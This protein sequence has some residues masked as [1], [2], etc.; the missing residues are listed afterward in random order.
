VTKSGR[1]TVQCQIPYANIE[2]VAIQK[3]GDNTVIAIQLRVLD[4]HETYHTDKTAF[5]T[6]EK[7]GM[8]HYSLHDHYQ[9]GLESLCRRI[10]KLVDAN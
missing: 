4:D 2:S 8:P 5:I 1:E 7:H 6:C 3:S 9:E 10:E